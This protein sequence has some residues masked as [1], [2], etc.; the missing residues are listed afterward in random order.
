MASEKP[1][2]RLQS[3]SCKGVLDFSNSETDR[4][5]TK[6]AADKALNLSLGLV[7]N[8]V[9][10]ARAELRQ[11]AFPSVPLFFNRHN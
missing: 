8:N 4:H 6:V 9:N 1:K 10:A 7:V 3:A 2:T 5:G 11:Q